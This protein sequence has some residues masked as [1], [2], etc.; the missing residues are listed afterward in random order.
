MGA[1][2]KGVKG[3]GSGPLG[4]MLGTAGG[5]AGTGIAG[6]RG[7]DIQAGTN[8][9]DVQGA[10]AGTA[11]SLASQQALLQALQSQN[12]LGQQ[13]AVAQQQQGLANQLQSAN[14]LGT[15]AAG[16][17]GL[18][19]VAGMQQDIAQG[20]GPN[21]AQAMLN[22]QTGQNVANQS[23]MMAGQRGAGGNP[24]LM[25]RQAAQQG[26]ATQQQAV[27][28]GATMQA[29]QQMNALSGLSSTN[30]AIAGLGGQQLA[31]QQAQQQ[32][33]ANQANNVANQQIAGT[34]ANTQGNLA[35]QNQMQG[36]LAGINSGIVSSQNNI[37]AA[38]AG[39]AGTEL[40]G[41]Q[42]F[43]GGA[44]KALPVIGGFF[45]GGGAV[46]KM[47]EG[48]AMG[49][50]PTSSFG[51]FLSGQSAGAVQVQDS[52]DNAA[53]MQSK[54]SLL[55]EKGDAKP[56]APAA[57][58]AGGE[59]LAGPDALSG[60]GSMAMMAAR[61]GLAERGGHVAAQ[62]PAQKAVKAGNSYDNDK[63]P[64]KLSEGEI[65]LPR[66]VTMSDDP[67]RDSADFVRK[68]LAKRRT[69]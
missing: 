40:Q 43:V 68:V 63:V 55:G 29:N 65:V 12:G 41:Q 13:N 30:Q 49:D 47:A 23:A 9:G 69:K 48:G 52:P 53:M 6:P 36:A 46:P 17:Q 54:P 7:A 50:G 61:G 8:V 1:V 24:A 34:S 3:L 35:N 21:P 20:R 32:N 51:Q 67:V 28:Q 5:M 10:Q 18:Q 38:N 39:I 2:S 22:Q 33:M 16:L 14:G 19:G 42:K 58:P 66:T 45:A 27:G 26:A 4:G 37:N 64:A 62:N 25:A 59:A 60:L 11:N 56:S 15:Q 44:A 57:A 31:A